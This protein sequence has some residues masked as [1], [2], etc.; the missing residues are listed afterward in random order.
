[1][2]ARYYKDAW[3]DGARYAL[4]FAEKGYVSSRRGDTF[5]QEMA[6]RPDIRLLSAY[7]VPFSREH[8]YR[9][10]QE[11]LAE[12][13]DLDFI[14]ASSTDI[15]QGIVDALEEAGRLDEVMVNGWGGGSYEL[16]AIEE[17]KL[18]FTVMRM[19][20]DNG[21]AMAEAVRLYLEGQRDSVPHVYAGDFHLIDQDTPVDQLE[22]WGRHAFRYSQ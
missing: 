7:Y 8:A 3:P 18:S 12:E 2:I 21:V 13:D 17:G 19:N 20:D 15:A 22:K 14:Y 11:L 9:A 4:F 10:A 5:L 16:E 6:E 1:M